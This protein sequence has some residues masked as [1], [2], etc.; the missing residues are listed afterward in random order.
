MCVCLQAAYQDS[1]TKNQ[2]LNVSYA[3][4]NTRTRTHTHRDQGPRPQ[5]FP[6]RVSPP[7][8][9]AAPT[10]P[11]HTSYAT[12]P[13]ASPTKAGRNRASQQRQIAPVTCDRDP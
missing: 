6:R 5:H 4:Y 11:P 12:A 13:F 10:K 9:R 7:P 3:A 8:A 2:A 1:V